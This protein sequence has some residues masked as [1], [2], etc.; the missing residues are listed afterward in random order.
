MVKSLVAA[1]TCIERLGT[2][3]L[4]PC[5]AGCQYEAK[6]AS[7]Y[8]GTVSSTYTAFNPQEEFA[9]LGFAVDAEVDGGR[10]SPREVFGWKPHQ[11]TVEL[12]RGEAGC[13][14]V[15]QAV[16]RA[17]D[18]AVDAPCIDEMNLE[19]KRIRGRPFYGMLRYVN[20]NMRGHVYIW[21]FPNESE[22]KI[23]Y[24][25]L[26]HEELSSRAS[27]QTASSMHL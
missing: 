5:L 2:L 22:T 20:Q 23:S 6:L 4:V 12:P 26:L 1:T 21:L 8:G 9:R 16:R 15:A 17:L 14:L 13:Q 10:V 25:I 7:E 24:A 19:R 18:R 27:Q 3:V 11:G